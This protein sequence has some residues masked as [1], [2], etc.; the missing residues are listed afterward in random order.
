MKTIVKTKLLQEI[1][2]KSKSVPELVK[3]HDMFGDMTCL[4]HKIDSFL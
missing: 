4:A 3:V 2:I 1:L